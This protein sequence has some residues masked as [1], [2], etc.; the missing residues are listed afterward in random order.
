VAPERGV[1]RNGK[2]GRRYMGVKVRIGLGEK[3]WTR[4]PLTGGGN[5]I[6]P[7]PGSFDL[8][9]ASEKRLPKQQSEKTIK[10]RLKF[11]SSL[12]QLQ[13]K[14]NLSAQ[15]GQRSGR[16]HGHAILIPVSGPRSAKPTTSKT[17]KLA[18]VPSPPVHARQWGPA[19]HGAKQRERGRGASSLCRKA[20]Q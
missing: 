11:K 10:E 1:P 8:R 12:A 2:G 13:D 4:K 16:P 5:Y 17:Q 14:R 20:L 15:K 6:L 3:I 19:I 9:A 7:L 18:T